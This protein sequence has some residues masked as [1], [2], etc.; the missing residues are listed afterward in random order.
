MSNGVLLK[1]NGTAI[2]SGESFSVEYAS[3]PPAPFVDYS[4]IFSGGSGS[5]RYGNP[6]EPYAVV[7]DGLNVPIPNRP[8][9]AHMGYWSDKLNG[10]I[11]TAQFDIVAD[12]LFSSAGISINFETGRD[13]FPN[14]VSI[15]WY[16]DDTQIASQVF[17]P[18]SARAFFDK[19]VEMYNKVHI[20][21]YSL[22]MPNHRFRIESISFGLDT[23][24]TGKYL[25]NIQMSQQIDPVSAQIPISTCNFSIVSEDIDFVFEKR[26]PIEVYFNDKLMG[27]SFI[28]NATQKTKTTYAVQCEDYIGVLDGTTF[29]GG[30]YE[31]Q[32]ASDI[33]LD[34][35]GVA[36]VPVEIAP[37]LES[38]L[39]SGHIAQCSCRS[40]LQ[41][42]LIASNGVADTSG[43]TLLRIKTLKNDLT[44]TIPPERIKQGINVSEE[45]RL[46]EVKVTQHSYVP[47]FEEITVYEAEKSGEGNNIEIV[48]TEPL[49]SLTITKGKII[50]Q[51]VNY[52]IIN[53]NKRC[54]LYGKKYLHLTSVKS[55][56]NTNVLTTD[57]ENAY[58]VTNATLISAD[59]VDKVLDV[60][61]NRYVKNKKVR[62]KIIDGR[63]ADGSFQKPVNLGD[64]I[65][66]ETPFSGTLQCVAES[67]SFHLNGGI[68][69]KDTVLR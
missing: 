13:V 56:K 1:Y 3:T 60:L 7:L 11:S 30:M 38:I 63:N 21:L 65:E 43:A 37:E 22:N 18:T 52:A 2:G 67:Q 47:D 40:A 39:L 41:Q 46:T 27:L 69:V 53:A 31:K 51:G 17:Y 62:A 44:Q 64:L 9:K 36:G 32:K 29:R 5:V 16:R 57:K 15:S 59:N 45:A 14:T 33:I 68:L 35:C 28:T 26:Q 8:E 4:Q 20:A 48:F 12:E 19:K 58:S 6:C 49:H 24:F 50:E 61:Y 42:V 55:R 34:I 25:Q 66:V 23:E 10:D 54:V